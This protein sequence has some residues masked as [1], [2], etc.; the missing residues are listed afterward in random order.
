VPNLQRSVERVK[1]VVSFQFDLN[2]GRAAVRFEEASP[3]ELSLLW[4]AVIDAGF[5]PAR[6]ESKGD[7]YTGP[8]P[9]GG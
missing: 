2:T 9:G 6:I 7:V 3:V 8:K 5:T 1:N 4:Q